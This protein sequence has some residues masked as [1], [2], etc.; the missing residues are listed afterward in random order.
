MT[1]E[2]TLNTEESL[3]FGSETAEKPRR[4]KRTTKVAKV[5]ELTPDTVIEEPT[6]E[7]VVEEPTPEPIVEEPTPEPVPTAKPWKPL[8][9]PL[10]KK[11]GNAGIYRGEMRRMR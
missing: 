11:S 5:E 7:P 2:N 6:P 8:V 10:K 1:E 3:G 9:R 4:R